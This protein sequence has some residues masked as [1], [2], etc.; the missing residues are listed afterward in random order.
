LHIFCS[1]LAVTDEIATGSKPWSALFDKH[2]FFTRYRYYLQI[3]ASSPN[4]EIQL[5]WYDKMPMPSG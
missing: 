4:A 5:K 1:G 2:D 3:T